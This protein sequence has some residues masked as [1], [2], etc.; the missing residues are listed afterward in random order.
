MQPLWK[1]IFLS[2][3]IIINLFGVVSE[4]VTG[5]E[6]LN[7]WVNVAAKNLE[8]YP[9]P[10][11]LTG[12]EGRGVLFPEPVIKY[13]VFEEIVERFIKNEK[14]F[15]SSNNDAWIGHC[16]PESLFDDIHGFVQG[17]CVDHL[18]TLVAL[19]DIHGSI[20]SL[21]RILKQLS[22]M[23]I[24]DE[25]Y[26]ISSSCK[27]IF[28]GDYADRGRYGVEVWYTVLRLKL[29]NPDKVFLIRGNHEMLQ[30]ARSYGFTYELKKKY[31]LKDR[32][33][34]R[35]IEDVLRDLFCLLPSAFFVGCGENNINFLQFCHGGMGMSYNQELHTLFKMDIE[36][37]LDDVA[38]NHKTMPIHFYLN[39]YAL[40]N[41]LLWGDFFTTLTDFSHIPDSCKHGSIVFSRGGSVAF[42]VHGN[43]IQH[44][45][46]N[47]DLLNLKYRV[48]AIIRGHQ[49]LVGGI[50]QLSERVL[51]ESWE[52]LSPGQETSCVST[53]HDIYPVFTIMSGAEGIGAS[54]EGF[55]LIRFKPEENNWALTPYFLNREP[56]S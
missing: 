46:F 10:A 1:L 8:E 16:V 51:T 38:Y 32:C 37:L 48:S 41:N 45:L 33:L 28:L 25:N 12:T 5:S 35:D 40:A 30:V 4:E 21:L 3:F 2:Q 6:N 34:I 29:A 49:H 11:L 39:G 55:A 31:N 54:G 20:H 9:T 27:L 19:G 13:E 14:I 23:G 24:I 53:N 7:V 50:Y 42:A 15:L 36:S 44:Y 22:C 26:I 56:L 52:L 17:L 18:I 47:G 43:L